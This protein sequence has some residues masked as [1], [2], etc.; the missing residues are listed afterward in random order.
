[1]AKETNR[2]GTRRLLHGLGRL[3]L[4]APLSLAFPL[5][6]GQRL[7]D[8]RP[9]ITVVVGGER[10][11]VAP[12]TTFADVVSTQHLA[13]SAG[14]LLD[15][16]GDVL[17]DGAYPGRILMNGEV[18]I[19][20]PRLFDGWT[21]QVV[22]GRD[23]TEGLVKKI[24][25]I[26]AGQVGNPQFFLGTQPGEQ[27]ITKGAISDKVVSSVFRPTGPANRPLDVALTF[28]DGP[29]PNSTGQILSILKKYKVKATFFVIGSV[30]QDR[31]NV[32]KDELKAGMEVENHS[33]DHPTSFSD[34]PP[35]EIRSEIKHC[36]D[37]LRS[38]GV[39]PTLFRPPGGS[40]SDRAISI[41]KKLGARLVLW[42]V[43][44]RDWASGAT[45]KQIVKSV[46]DNVRPGSVIL[47]HDG[48]GNRSATVK[49]LPKIIRGIKMMGLGF[50]TI[51]EG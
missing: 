41:A 44:P 42:S 14:D 20:D 47:M 13:A 8:L 35:N 45:T 30:A 50:T 38:L 2:G 29:W 49:A 6:G 7:A 28:D 31:P 9:M 19:G 15:V 18:P 26:P 16:E 1:M 37:Y 39:K 22:N 36:R 3:A 10:I 46:L 24:V 43:D 25:R 21:L 17:R 12:G 34:L 51:A 27:V 32:V 5:A 48:G 11:D 33:W 40:Y 23:R 4:I